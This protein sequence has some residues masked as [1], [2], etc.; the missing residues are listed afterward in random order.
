MN[1]APDKGTFGIFFQSHLHTDKILSR[2]FN[3]TLMGRGL[4]RRYLSID[5]Q[6]PVCL[7]DAY[8]L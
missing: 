4:V 6:V 3:M 5:L 7:F 1:M 2:I 8:M